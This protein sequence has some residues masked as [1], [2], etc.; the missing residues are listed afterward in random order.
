MTAISRAQYSAM[1]RASIVSSGATN[2]QAGRLGINAGK[3][4]ST[5]YSRIYVD[6]TRRAFGHFLVPTTGTSVALDGSGN[7]TA[8]YEFILSANPL[9]NDLGV[10]NCW[11]P[12]QISGGGGGGLG[13]AKSSSTTTTVVNFSTPVYTSGDN[14]TRF[15]MTVVSGGGTLGVVVSNPTASGYLRI[16]PAT[17]NGVAVTEAQSDD[18]HPEAL[19]QSSFG[20]AVQPQQLTVRGMDWVSVNNSTDT[21]WAGSV[22][23]GTDGSIRLA[24][25]SIDELTRYCNANMQANL[26][27]NVPALATDDYIA[28]F[29]AKIDAR[30]APAS[31]AYLEFVNEPWNPLFTQFNLVIQAACRLATTYAG[32]T[33]SIPGTN[34]ITSC[35][36]DGAGTATAIITGAPNGTTGS[37]IF[38]AGITSITGGYVAL[39]NVVNNGNGTYSISWAEAGGAVT[40]TVV[41]GG[42]TYTSYIHTNVQPGAAHYIVKGLTTYGQQPANNYVNVLVMGGRYVVERLRAMWTAAQ[43]LSGKARF[44][45]VMNNSVG[46]GTGHGLGEAEA[47]PYAFERFG[48]HS[49][50]YS[51]ASAPYFSSDTTTQA[52]ASTD[53]VFAALQ[54]TGGSSLDSF[55]AL[56]VKEGTASATWGHP[57]V[58]YEGGPATTTMGTAGAFIGAAHRDPRMGVM[59]T[60]MLGYMRD[61]GGQTGPACYYQG[62]SSQTF[63]ASNNSCWA[64][65]ENGV[66]NDFVSPKPAALKA[67]L[68]ATSVAQPVDTLTSGT[69]SIPA[70]WSISTGSGNANG[71]IVAG[72]TVVLPDLGVRV[73]KSVAG[74]YPISV[75]L[76]S[77]NATDWVTIL[78]NGVEVAHQ[79]PLTAQNPQSGPPGS[80]VWSSASYPFNAGANVVKVI[81]KPTRAG[82]VGYMQII[83][84][85]TP[86]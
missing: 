7:P 61:L 29:V 11:I 53:A 2:L 74:N 12:G 42:N 47:Y 70:V 24:T 63:G 55:P 19:T 83:S 79:T 73:V 45:F 64:L 17:I 32:N 1:L 5:Q 25:E 48:D 62:G 44:R 18:F 77:S 15:T 54:S 57:K 4:S 68:A 84:P 39:T 69:I 65:H 40:G 20:T 21:D 86:V 33:A 16:L 46:S 76:C 10:Y 31:I 22:A 71:C 85:N 9:A 35:T 81:M 66:I 82:I 75:W 27:S 49:W 72:T 80:A 50:I 8:S 52:A 78:I 23:A 30:L 38:V 14:T 13:I 58:Y 67:W 59:E 56:L 60:T 51:I 36:R 41:S 28:Q 3:T 26:W 43:A 34:S 6:Y 37:M